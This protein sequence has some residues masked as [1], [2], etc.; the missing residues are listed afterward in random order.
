VKRRRR[1]SAHAQRGIDA[2]NLG[3]YLKKHDLDADAAVTAKG[4]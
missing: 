4:S 3:Y 2:R 1:D